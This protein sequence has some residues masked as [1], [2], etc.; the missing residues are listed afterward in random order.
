M[1]TN[2]EWTNETWSPITGCTPISEGCKNCYAKR[3][4]KRLAGR[5]GYPEQPHEFDVTLHPEK[6]NQ[7]LHWKKPRMIF[8]CSMGD[9][10]HKDVEYEWIF[11]IFAV[12]SLNQQHTFQILT[13]RPE[14]M[15]KWFD[16]YS[17]GGFGT[18]EI[19]KSR[20]NKIK[21]LTETPAGW[22]NMS[23]PLPNVWL[24]VTAENQQTANERI[25][26]L[27]KTPAAVR[28]VSVEPMLEGMMVD[29]YLNKDPNLA[30][31]DWV[32]C[33]GET[34]PRAREM[35]TEWA[36][37]LYRQ[38]KE[39]GAPFFFKKPGDAFKGNVE[40]LPMVREWPKGSE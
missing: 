37:D 9:L 23:W 10:F 13:K 3:M 29:G 19:V 15:K 20:A 21:G 17:V 2:I 12:M 16:Y 1:P 28:F 11:K 40:D 24:G 18:R 27:L 34:G 22:T 14:N 8:V 35:K 30:T 36:R 31:L 33:G 26:G 25:P 32:I 4:A 5:Y 39:D 7:P 38:C 6:L